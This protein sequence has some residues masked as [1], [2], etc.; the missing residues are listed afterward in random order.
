MSMLT[1]YQLNGEDFMDKFEAAKFNL[2]RELEGADAIYLID[3]VIGQIEE[4]L[5]E[6]TRKQAI[7]AKAKQVT[8]ADKN[9]EQPQDVLKLIEQM[10]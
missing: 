3:R 10:R 1:N 7:T 8:K 2:Q 6:S 9:A 4:R 5:L